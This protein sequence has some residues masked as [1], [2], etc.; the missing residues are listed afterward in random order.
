MQAHILLHLRQNTFGFQPHDKPR[1]VV[2]LRQANGL[3]DDGQERQAHVAL[4]PRPQGTRS[5][6][7]ALIL[8]RAFGKLGK[9]LADAGREIGQAQGIGTIRE[10]LIGPEGAQHL[11]QVRFTRSV[12]T[13]DP[14]P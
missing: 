12:E 3:E 6:M 11:G 5:G 14:D 9:L 8:V 13:T 1:Q 7:Q 4:H 2:L 10:A